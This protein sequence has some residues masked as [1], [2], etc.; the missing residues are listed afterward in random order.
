M[1]GATRYESMFARNQR[2]RRRAF[3]PFTVLGDP[4][5]VTSLDIVRTLV[6]SG[7]DALEL[8]LAFSDPVADGTSIQAADLRALEAGTTVEHAWSIVRAVRDEFP[9][10]PIG[11]LVYA[12]LVVHDSS[13]SFYG[14]AA[15]AGVGTRA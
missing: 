2:D 12:N 6:R 5:P 4:D 8:G 14:S 3:V 15:M 1:S 9:E 10:V 11:L 13:D 7:A